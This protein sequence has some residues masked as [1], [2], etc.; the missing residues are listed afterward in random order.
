MGF[1]KGSLK[2]TSILLVAVL[3]VSIISAGIIPHGVFGGPA[4]AEASGGQPISDLRIGDKVVDPSWQWEHRFN[5]PNYEGSDF[6]TTK[7]VTWI[8]VAK[9]HYTGGASGSVSG[10]HVTLLSEDLITRYAFDDSTNRGHAAGSNHWGN[11]GLP[12][13]EHGARVFLN[14]TFY[15]AMSSS[16]QESILETTLPNKVGGTGTSYT[17]KDK[18]F[19]PSSTELGDK[20]HFRT[21]V[22]GAD[23]GYFTDNQSRVAETVDRWKTK[24]NYWTRSPDSRAPYSFEV[25][26]VSAITGAIEI[27]GIANNGFICL[28]PALNLSAATRVSTTKNADGVYEILGKEVIEPVEPPD[29]YSSVL[30]WQH[31]KNGQ[32]KA[33]YMDGPELIVKSALTPGQMDPGWEIKA[34]I[35]MNG[36]DNADLVWQHNDGRLKVWYMDGLKKVSSLPILRPGGQEGLGDPNWQ[37]MA[38]YDLN[39]DGSPDIIFQYIGERLDGQLAVWLMDGLEA[40]RFGRLFNTPGNAYV[41]PLWEIGAVFDLLGNGQP[42]VI[43]QSVSGGEFDQLAYWQLDVDGDE[44]TRS[45][46]RRLEQVGGSAMIRSQWRMKTAVDLLGKGKHEILFQGISGAL[47]GRVSYWEM[48][49]V[50]RLDGGRLTPERVLDPAWRLAGSSN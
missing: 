3:F 7:P 4:V 21:H 15:N 41:S 38:V 9:N 40:D 19:V 14:D 20:E 45:G 44:F 30:Y 37:I 8:V 31:E 11:S 17:T 46:S 23:W 6:D 34:V 32:L 35:D 48:E 28:R 13:A 42:E 10:N 27:D 26:F 29:N 1:L 2:I 24:D 25:R 33:W 43:W 18:V 47:D 16:F 12:N 36:N 39:S 22:I 50:E 49:G 5:M